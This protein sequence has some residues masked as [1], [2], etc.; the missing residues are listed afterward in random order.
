MISPQRKRRFFGLL[1]E[2]PWIRFRLVLVFFR[3][4]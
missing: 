2:L 4:D 1:A 3:L